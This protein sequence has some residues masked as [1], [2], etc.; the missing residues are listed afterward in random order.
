MNATSSLLLLSSPN[1]EQVKMLCSPVVSSKRLLLL[2]VF[3]SKH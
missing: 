2:P 1:F 3:L